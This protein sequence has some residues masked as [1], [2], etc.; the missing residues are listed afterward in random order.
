MFNRFWE[1]IEQLD[2]NVGGYSE[3]TVY[4]FNKLSELSFDK[5][6]SHNASLLA[7]I[8]AILSTLEYDRELRVNMTT[9][10]YQIGILLKRSHLLILEQSDDKILQEVGKST[11]NWEQRKRSPS[12]TH[13]FSSILR[14]SSVA[15][16]TSNASF[17]NLLDAEI[18][19]SKSQY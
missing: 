18:K 15:S 2:Y 8:R 10:T 7:E 12:L 19:K 1:L 6:K 16:E 5:G 4:A 13:T 9:A 17:S 3:Q 11:K 14:K